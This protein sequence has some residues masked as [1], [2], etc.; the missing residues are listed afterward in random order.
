MSHGTLARRITPVLRTATDLTHD[1]YKAR[2]SAINV[3]RGLRRPVLKMK[4]VIDSFADLKTNAKGHLRDV[5]HRCNKECNGGFLALG[6][7]RI[8][9]Y[10]VRS[11]IIPIWI[12]YKH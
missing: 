1:T 12:S 5:G 6:P 7:S 8:V 10:I 3:T 11:S 2:M 4:K 9:A